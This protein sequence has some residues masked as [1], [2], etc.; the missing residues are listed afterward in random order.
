MSFCRFNSRFT[1]NLFSFVKNAVQLLAILSLC[2]PAFSQANAGRIIGSITDQSGGAMAGATVTITDIQRGTSRTL[3]SDD[4]GEYSAPNLTPGTYKVHVEAKGFK[5][6]ERPS[7]ILEVGG[8]V[9]VDLVLQ[10][11]EQ[12]QTITVTEA[13]PLVE[14]TNAE[15]GGT[16]QNVIINDLPLNGRNFENLLSLRP[17]VTVYPGGGGWTQSTNGM[18]AHDNVYLVDGVNSNDP[19]MAQSIMNA[20]MASGDAGTILPI[21][22]I[23]EFKTG[24]NPKAEYGWKPG[25]IVNVGIKSGTNALH[26]TAYAFGRD[27]SWDARDYFNPAPNVV[28]PLEFEQFGA[29]LGGPIKKDKLFFFLNYEDQRYSVGNPVV[30][31]NIPITG[32][33]GAS[34]SNG[35]ITACKTALAGTGL[36]PVSAQLAGLSSTCVPLSNYPGLFPVNNSGGTTVATDINST[37]QIDAGLV[38]G[39]YHINDKNTLTGTYFISPGNGILAD[40]TLSQLVATQLTNQYARSQVS[41]V[42]WTWTPNSSWVNEARVGYSHYYQT[43]V[44]NDHTEDPANYAFNGATYHLFTGQTNPVYFGLPAISFSSSHFTMGA[45]WPKTV[46]PD[47]VLEIVDHVSVLHGKQ[48]FKFGVEVMRNTS[49]NNVTSNAKGPIRFAD[50]PSFFEG[51]PN[52]A[53]FLSGNLLRHMSNEG[54]AGFVQDDWR[55]TPRLTVNLGLRYEID[56]VL[57]E[58]DGLLGNFDPSAP[59][60]MVQIGK[61]ES[62]AYNGDHNNFAPRIG[63]A[64]DVRGNGKTVVRAGGGIMY[65]QFSYDMFNAIGNLLG[66]RMV[67]TGVPLYANG[68]QVP[69]TGTLNVAN[70]T[71][72]GPALTGTTTRGQVAFDWIHNSSSQPLYSTSP[73]CGDGTVTLASGLTPQPC[74]IAGVARNLRNP[75]VTTWT[76]DIQRAL[77]SN[78]SLDVGYVG[79]HGTKFIGVQDVNQPPLGAGWNTPAGGM[80]A[81]QVCLAT[82]H[83][84]T[85]CAPDTDAEQ[86]ARP[87][88]AK[89]PYLQYIDILSNQNES[90]YNGLQV[91]LTQ[92]TSHGLSFTAGYTYSHALDDSSDNWACCIPIYNDRPNL[93]YGNSV[94]DITHRFTLSVT[95]DLPG[96]KGFGQ[97]L[98]GWS[99]NSIVSLQTGLP[100]GAADTSNDFSGTG[101]LNQPADGQEEQWD[102]FGNPK[103][104]QI[105]HGLV[106]NNGDALNGGSGGIPFFPG[107]GDPTAPTTNTT[108]NAKAAA[109]GALASAALANTGCFASGGSVMIPP[110]YGTYGQMGKNIFRDGGFR[111]WDFSI[112]KSFK[113]RERL[114]AQFRAEFFNVLN[115]PEFSNPG[116][117]GGGAGTTDPSVGAGF[118]CGC[119][120]PDTGGSNPVLGSGG[121]RAMQL[122][123]KLIF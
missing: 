117:P 18:R 52:R 27:S 48:A 63:L 122:G 74:S 44:S 90:N 36:A 82:P 102:F 101:E 43:F 83:D 105:K 115:H 87:F 113:F 77:T 66:L 97:L 11:G 56:G 106:A 65:E 4:S 89:F 50:F 116:G 69:N 12:N 75:Y 95:Y 71:F 38:K 73:A 100:W 86:A 35:L 24:E 70:T 28:S 88:N 62:S 3:T 39:D 114:T 32:G 15:L 68:K 110:A 96:K 84:S 16:L 80:T 9:R 118:G 58:R 123:L 49:T 53:N 76:L 46:G 19:W 119:V 79:N 7:V 111:N 5:A 45:S 72:S 104:F 23:D 108:C 13:L 59:T 60:G 31:T 98:E 14:T 30:H 121:P 6:T 85:N 51:I 57:K 47:G 120:T 107:S 40:N 22:A 109:L 8:E 33:A 25:A 17:G 26:G 103:D 55:M 92:R 61:G 10:P 91:A 1:N 29:T 78:L 99:V 2:L 42:N 93:L 21:D 20:G 54:F 67:P 64:W 41:A 94:F 112:F 37:N 81:A 34:G